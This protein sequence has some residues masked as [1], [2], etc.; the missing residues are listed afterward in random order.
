[1]DDQ[2]ICFSK[3][4]IECKIFL[5]HQLMDRVFFTDDVALSGDGCSCDRLIACDH[6][7]FDSSCVAFCNGKGN[8]VSWR[9]VKRHNPYKAL[10]VKREIGLYD[11]VYV[12][13]KGVREGTRKMEL[14]EPKDSLSAIAEIIIRFLENLLPMLIFGHWFTMHKDVSAHLPYFFRRA[15]SE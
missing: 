9:I 3:R 10:L 7:N 11:L 13:L 14:G 15:L 1:M 8:R 2:R 12:E 6:D 5:I 4:L